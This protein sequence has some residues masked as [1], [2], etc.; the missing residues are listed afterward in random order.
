[1]LAVKDLEL[2]I[3]SLVEKSAK[4]DQLEVILNDLNQTDKRAIERIADAFYD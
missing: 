4:L 3:N 2:A 1:M